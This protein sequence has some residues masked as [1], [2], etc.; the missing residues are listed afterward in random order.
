MQEY[1]AYV[2]DPD[3]HISL[4]HD[5]SARDDE[6]AKRHA[7]QYVDGQDV[8]LWQRDRMIT[9]LHHVK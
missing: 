8:E 3:G 9:T 5:F 2:M 1:R 7:K 4:R 6:A